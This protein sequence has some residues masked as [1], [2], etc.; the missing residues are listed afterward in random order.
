MSLFVYLLQL[1]TMRAT[2]QHSFKAIEDWL[3]PTDARRAN[4]RCLDKAKSFSK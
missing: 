4:V 3:A 2:L 1:L